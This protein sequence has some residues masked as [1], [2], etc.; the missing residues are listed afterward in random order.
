M[1]EST[2]RVPGAESLQDPRDEWKAPTLTRL[3][4]AVPLTLGATGTTPDGPGLKPS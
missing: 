3:G 2:N 1:T 4:D